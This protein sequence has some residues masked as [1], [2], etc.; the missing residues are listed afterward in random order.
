MNINC[1]RSFTGQLKQFY[2]ILRKDKIF[3]SDTHLHS[4]EQCKDMGTL[5][6]LV[7][8]KFGWSSS[9]TNTTST[10][11]IITIDTGMHEGRHHILRFFLLFKKNKSMRIFH[12]CRF[13]GVFTNVLDTN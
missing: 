13:L 11:N 2:F 8:T 3:H 4:S 6:V 12:I 10:I 9:G 1:P 5:G 7:A